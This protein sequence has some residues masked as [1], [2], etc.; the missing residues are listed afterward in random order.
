M[1]LKRLK[2]T[3]ID[4]KKWDNVILN[5]DLPLVFAQSFYLNSTC[6]NWDAL[7]INDYETVFPLTEKQ[8]FG[9][10]YLPQPPFTSQLGAFG[11]ISY[12]REKLFYDYL[13]QH[14]N[15]IEIELNK[16]NQLQSEYRQNKNTFVINYNNGFSY[17]QNTKR[18][19]L[20]A[21]NIGLEIKEIEEEEIINLSR[22]YLNPFLHKEFNLSSHSLQLFDNLINNSI[23]NNYIKTFA[24][25]DSKGEIRAL[26]HFLCNNIHALFLKGTNFDRVEN[27]GSMHFLLDYAIGYFKDKAKIFDFGGGSNSLGLASF[28]KGFGSEQFDYGFLK[29][30]N[31]PRIIKFLKKQV[32]KK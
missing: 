12:E 25:I 1:N 18:N 31:L 3:E 2:H 22:I 28:Y 9:Y 24:V 7:I 23:Q 15:L 11:I 8:K 4:F 29:I 21:V 16:T 27:S 6:P 10:T 19:I 17:N 5:S 20:K 32:S 26:A 30:N 13:I 14:Y